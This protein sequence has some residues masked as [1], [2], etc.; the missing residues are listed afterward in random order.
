MQNALLLMMS[1]LVL[2]SAS[3]SQ[4]YKKAEVFGGFQ[5]A[6]V[7]PNANGI[8]WNTAIT[9]NLTHAIGFTADFS[10]AMS[11]GRRCTRT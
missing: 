10:G 11:A 1:L 3:L 9:G 4:E 8:G 6:H 5:Y 7:Y 2:C